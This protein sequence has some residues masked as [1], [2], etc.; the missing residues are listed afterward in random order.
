MTL[1]ALCD[2]NHW[3]PIKSPQKH[4]WPAFASHEVSNYK[5]WC[6]RCCLIEQAVKTFALSVIWDAGSSCD[7]SVAVNAVNTLQRRHNERLKSPASRLFTHLFIQTQ[8]TET[9]KASRHWPF[10]AGGYRSPVNSTHKWPVTRKMFQFD[11][12]VSI[13]WRHYDL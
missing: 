12:N 6:F 3:P 8:I 1:L 9:I 2:G 13:W 10:C 7:Q 5:F 11:E 4:L